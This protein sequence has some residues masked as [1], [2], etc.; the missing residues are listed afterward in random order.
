MTIPGGRGSCRAVSYY[1]ISVFPVLL[2]SPVARTL[3][4]SLA[5]PTI[6]HPAPHSSRRLFRIA[7]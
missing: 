3:G 7:G 4:G 1:E 6:V 2:V 5:L